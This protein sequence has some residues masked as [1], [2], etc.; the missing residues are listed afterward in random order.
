MKDTFTSKCRSYL[1]QQQMG[2]YSKLT[3]QMEH[4]MLYE[5]P[6]LQTKARR[7]IPMEELDRKAQSKLDDIKVFFQNGCSLE[8][9]IKPVHYGFSIGWPPRYQCTCFLF[10]AE[11]NSCKGIRGFT[12]I[13]VVWEIAATKLSLFKISCVKL[14]SETK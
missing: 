14:F 5:D 3:S 4:V 2:F 11:K 12:I 8:L 1:Q 9:T 13:L 10:T 6:N 7:C